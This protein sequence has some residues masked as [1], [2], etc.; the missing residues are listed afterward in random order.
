MSNAVERNAAAKQ[1]LTA[2][3]SLAD[4][5]SLRDKEYQRTVNNLLEGIVISFYPLYPESNFAS[6]MK[7]GEKIDL[8]EIIRRFAGH[9]LEMFTTA[10][11]SNSFTDI[12]NRFPETIVDGFGYAAQ[13]DILEKKPHQDTAQ[14][15]FDLVAE[16]R[17]GRKK[18]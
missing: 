14:Q 16:N 5:L 3:A 2:I 9:G 8:G 10:Y 13:S 6:I 15:I 1:T 17:T 18:A 7:K 11:L 12:I 4:P